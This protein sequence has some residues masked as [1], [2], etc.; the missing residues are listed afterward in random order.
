MELPGNATPFEYVEVRFK[1]SRKE[2]YRNATKNTLNAGDVVVV[3]G[4]PGHDV[5]TI[6]ASGELARL[7]MEKKKQTRN[8][9]DLRKVIR[10]ATS[11]D[12]EKWRE[13][14]ALEDET[15]RQA[16]T[17][18]S[19]LGL[20][21]K[22]SDVEYQGDKS[23]AFFYYT[24]EGRVDFR[25]LIKRYAEAFRIRVE[26]KQIGA[27]QEASRLGGIGSCGRELCC[28][29]WLTDFRSVSTSAAR[30]QQLALNTSKLAGQC[31]KLKCCL[32]YELDSYMDA[33]KSFPKHH[34]KLKTK[35]GNA[36]HL[37][38]DIF[39]GILWYV[40]D[41]AGSSTP[42]PLKKE[43]V[44]EIIEMN[45][46][47]ILPEDLK[48]YAEMLD[49]S[50]QDT[51]YSNVVGQDSLTRFDKKQSKGKSKRRKSQGNRKGRGPQASSSDAK[52]STQGKPRN[53][54]R[55]KSRKPSNNPGNKKS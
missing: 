10:K 15:M 23:K 31:G 35:K 22:I 26:M 44:S 24:A 40:Y 7:Q 51:S 17:I 30:Y 8:T 29:T 9:K 25:E 37:K 6:S 5:G 46:K 55:T 54:R 14:R 18:A 34:N 38:T 53:K 42:V 21:M 11:Q 49:V 16:R 39:K 2:F 47:G 27:R 48:D 1:N 36:L 4:S 20:E 33:L 43:R 3:E 12:L 19:S 52:P 13:A 41:E 50:T 28:S 45:K 32:N